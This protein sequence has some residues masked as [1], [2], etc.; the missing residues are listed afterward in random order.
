HGVVTTRS[1]LTGSTSSA[2]AWLDAMPA[3][4]ALYS[5]GVHWGCLVTKET[6]AIRSGSASM[7]TNRSVH[8]FIE[9]MR[10]GFAASPEAGGPAS[11]AA[12]ASAAAVNSNRAMAVG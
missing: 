11:M 12:S 1:G 2:S 5:G 10:C 9:T 3:S 7:S 4:S 8:W 6:E